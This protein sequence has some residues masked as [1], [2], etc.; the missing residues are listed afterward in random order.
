MLLSEVS[1]APNEG[2][3][4][5]PTCG[6][7]SQTVIRLLEVLHG[8]SFWLD[9]IYIYATPRPLYPRERDPV[10]VVQEAGWASESVWISVGNLTHPGIRSPNRP[11]RSES[12]Y[13]LSYHSPR[14][15]IQT[16]L[17]Y[18]LT[19]LKFGIAK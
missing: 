15:L 7:T 14:S 19:N 16:L 10:T 13:L 9:M 11:A 18:G 17:Y 3:F 8:L 5:Q 1:G 6:G 12:V 4:Q 2:R